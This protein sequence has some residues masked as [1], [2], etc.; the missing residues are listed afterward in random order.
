MN[1][2]M[3]KLLNAFLVLTF[4][5]GYLEWGGGN[6]TFIFQAEAEILRKLVDN[7]IEVLHP[8][9]VI[10]FCGQV[11]LLITMFQ[12]TP[13]RVLTLVGL[14]CL[15]T[16]ILFLFFIGLISL[17]LKVLGSTIPFLVTGGLV[18]RLNW[19]KTAPVKVY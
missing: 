19:K 14:T 8:F 17:N 7:P 3:K 11:L 12:G 16:I 1:F 4:L 5:I 2:E 9:T 18:L 10:P 13:N 15:S 6:Q